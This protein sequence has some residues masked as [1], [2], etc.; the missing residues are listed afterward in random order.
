MKTLFLLPCVLLALGSLG[1]GSDG[2]GMDDVEKACSYAVSLSGTNQI[3][4][5]FNADEAS[6]SQ[7]KAANKLCIEEMNGLPFC[8]DE[9][10]QDHACNYDLDEGHLDAQDDAYQAA[11]DECC[12]KTADKCEKETSHDKCMNENASKMPCDKEISARQS[13]MSKLQE[14]VDADGQPVDFNK[15]NE[16][17]DSYRPKYKNL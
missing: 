8:K 11:I 3:E 16:Y 4:M 15:L 12:N 13:C 7:I 5:D 10:I 2:D 9:L 1:C 6:K 14:K 17:L